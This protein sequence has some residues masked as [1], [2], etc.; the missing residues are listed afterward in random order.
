MSGFGIG[1]RVPLDVVLTGL[2][3][4]RYYASV[5]TLHV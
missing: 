2:T 4:F 5:G 3:T 1:T